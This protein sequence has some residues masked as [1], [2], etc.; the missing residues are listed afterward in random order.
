MFTQLFDLIDSRPM[1][2][3]ILTIVLG[4]ILLWA[5]LLILLRYLLA[6]R[7]LTNIERMQMIEAGQ[8]GE[9]LKSF[10]S[11]LRR[12]R[13]LSLALGLFVPCTALGGATLV[14]IC[15]QEQSAISFVAWIC[16][17]IASVAS[18]ICGTIATVRQ[19]DLN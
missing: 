7:K 4:G 16:A 3:L 13:F 14:S 8:S 10:E 19:Y 17:A 11:Q 5:C 15:T 12:N 9:L 6:Y 2:F 18:T 1:P